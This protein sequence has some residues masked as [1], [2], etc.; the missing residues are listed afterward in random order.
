MF[1]C[2]FYI[3]YSLVSLQ[4]KLQSLLKGTTIYH[5]HAQGWDVRM[6]RYNKY[7]LIFNKARLHVSPEGAFRWF[8]FVSPH[9]AEKNIIIIL[10]VC[11]VINLLDFMTSNQNTQVSPAFVRN[12]ALLNIYEN[13]SGITSNANM[14]VFSKLHLLVFVNPSWHLWGETRIWH[15]S[16]FSSR[17][18]WELTKEEKHQDVIIALS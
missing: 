3:L 6:Q 4:Y 7:N 12:V 13:C 10:A 11:F 9:N 14:T 2:L 8:Y 18:M 5:N 16:W 15:L 1:F 17:F